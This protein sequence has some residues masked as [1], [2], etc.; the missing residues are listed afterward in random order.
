MASTN[1]TRS[2]IDGI[3]KY[4]YAPELQVMTR[5]QSI[6]LGLM[7][8]VLA[9]KSP[10]GG[11]SFIIPL[12]QNFMGSTG[13]RAEGGAL[14]D[15]MPQTW[16]NSVVPIDYNYFAI[17]V[18]GQAIKTSGNTAYAWTDAWT[19]DVLLTHRS[20]RQ[21]MNRQINGDG[22]GILAQVD[23]TPAIGATYTVVT[24]DNAYGVSGRN[25]SAVNGGKFVTANTKVDFYTSTAISGTSLT[26]VDQSVAGAFPSTSA[27]IRFV[28]SGASTILD[29]DYMYIAGNYGN[30]MPGIALLIDDGTAAVT[31]QSLSTTTYPDWKAIVKY[32]STPGTAEA[33][34]TARMSDLVDEIESKSEGHVDAFVTSNAVW[35]TVGEIMRQE[36]YT[37]NPTKLD[38]GK[39][40]WEFDGRPVYKDPYSLDDIYA[41]DKSA[42]KLFEAAPQGW[43]EDGDSVISKVAGYDV[44]TAEWAWYMTP[45]VVNRMK[46]GKLMDISVVVNKI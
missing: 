19:R 3:L 2:T 40:V 38:T 11:K 12:E 35:L 4:D 37:V 45:G 27:A 31:F 26:V 21:Q 7:D 14:P 28:N 5:E 13:A 46:L 23:G 29:G 30:E 42:I 32:G 22:N 1:T 20:F 10:Y 24:L 8:T 36:G 9:Q 17:N 44:Y 16:L 33:W 25:N 41:I 43:L 15:A 34:T 18:T 39:I 6:L